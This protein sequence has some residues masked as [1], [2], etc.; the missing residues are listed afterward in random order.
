LSIFWGVGDVPGEWGRE[1]NFKVSKEGI[2]NGVLGPKS[3]P[4]TGIF[5]RF[6]GLFGRKRA[7]LRGRFWRIVRKLWMV[8]GEKVIREEGIVNRG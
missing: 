1:T 7:F 5:W 4:K 8:F 6:I 2:A 3:I